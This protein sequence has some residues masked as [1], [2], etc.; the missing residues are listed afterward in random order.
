MKKLL[1]LNG[2]SN[3]LKQY[4]AESVEE[5][6]DYEIIL[7]H[8]LEGT[9]AGFWDWHIKDNYE[10][11]S[12]EFKRMFGYEDHE[13]PNHPDSWQKIIHPDDL[14]GVF[15]IFQKHVDSKGK[16]PYDNEVR[17]FHKNGSIVWVFCRGK[18]IE[19]DAEGN[20]VRMIGSHIDI[21]KLKEAENT[22]KLNKQLEEKN[23]ELERFAYVASHDLQ[24][25]LQ[26]INVFSKLLKE[27][28]ETSLGK[29]GEDYINYISE[30]TKKMSTLLRSLLDYSL[31]G[32][33]DKVTI[34]N[35][36]ELIS[37]IIANNKELIEKTE[38]TISFSH[39]PIIYAYDIQLK[40]VFQNLI[41]NAI[42]FHKEGVPPKIII[43]CEK[44]KDGWKF[45]ISD[46]G[47]GIKKE[48]LERIFL[49]FQKLKTK[50]TGAGIGLAFCRKI[51]DLHKGDIWIESEFSVGTDIF[52]TIKNINSI[53]RKNI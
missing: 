34:C 11:M 50:N 19:W 35:C 8:I 24:E 47:Q 21:T 38:T 51:I 29:E 46:N 5:N 2:I 14:P 26:T 17:Y 30:A 31:I 43:S 37:D 40:L 18:V 48:N 42:S 9:M 44:Q 6:V 28:F 15:D 25:P 53:N 4:F 10:Y 7:G 20:P 52:F 22:K 1:I 13:I 49:I 33:E 36:N 23:Q 39:L 27:E 16:F 3:S 41:M 12:P 32:T 45:K